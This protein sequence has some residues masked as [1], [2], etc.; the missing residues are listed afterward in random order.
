MTNALEINQLS[1]KYKGN[2]EYSIQK[3]NFKVQKGEFHGFIGANGAGKT[4]TIKSIVG[5]YA[6]F[7]GSIKI[8]DSKN[9]TIDAKK[10]LGYIPENAKFPRGLNTYQF[11]YY[12]S[13]ISGISSPDAKKHTKKILNDTNLV[14]LA[15]K[16]PNNFSSGQKKKVLLAQSLVH[17]PD[18][19]IMDEPAAN[20]DPKAREEFFGT[21]KK[22]QKQGKSIFISS[23]ILAELDSYVD[24]V[25]I[26]DGGKVAYSGKIDKIRGTSDFEYEV[27]VSDKKIIEKFI[28]ENNLKKNKNIIDFQNQK[29]I[30][31]F[32][33]YVL[34]EKVL[35]TKFIIF[36][37]TLKDIYADKVKLGSMQ[38]GIGEN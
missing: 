22:L 4:T 30:D 37:K 25:T 10:R 26:I 32:L 9:N 14:K 18:L 29:N 6:K 7:E 8:F 23:H 2:K 11:I 35:L 34:K 1:K 16:N 15:K 21:L 3:L 31:S 19:I 24:S 5:A 27:E 13:R 28:K 38:T 33:K 36:K 20:L 17:S 12:L